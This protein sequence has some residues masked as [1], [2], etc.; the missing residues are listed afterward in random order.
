MD[1]NLVL[2]LGIKMSNLGYVRVSSEGQNISRQ[3]DGI[4]LDRTFVDRVSGKDKN[5][6]QLAALLSD[7]KSGDTIYV[8]SMDRLA[9]NLTDL[10]SLVDEI[11]AKGGAIKFVKEGLEFRPEKERNPM[12]VLLMQMLGAVAQFERSLIKER[13]REGIEKAK[14][15]GVYKGRKPIDKEKIESAKLLVEGGLSIAKAAKQ[16]GISQ[17]VLYKY[18]KR[19]KSRFTWSI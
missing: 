3:L 16:L 4:S 13:Q 17:S 12:S 7:I 14:A 6:P 15:R 9:R 5:R 8:H 10:Q 19:G 18:A 11:N 1:Q 2:Q